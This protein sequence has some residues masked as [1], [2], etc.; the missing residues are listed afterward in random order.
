MRACRFTLALILALLL[1]PAIARGAVL[2]GSPGVAPWSDK[3]AGGT[4]EA[5]QY[6]ATSSGIVQSVSL[7]GDSGETTSPILVGI[8]S[9]VNNHPGVPLATTVIP[10]PRES[11]WNTVSISPVLVTAGSTYW[12]A[13]LAT[14]G[15]LAVRD[16][17]KGQGPTEESQSHGLL[18]LPASW[19]T[20]RVWANSPASFYASGTDVLEEVVEPEEESREA[21][22]EAAAETAEREAREKSEREGQAG[23]ESREE[24]LAR[25]REE[26]VA[27]RQERKAAREARKH[28]QQVA[29]ETREA[30]EKAARENEEKVTREGHEAEERAARE[31]E[32]QATREREAQEHEQQQ[33]GTCTTTVGPATAASTIA[34]DIRGAA[35]GSTVCL[36]AGN[37]PQLS[38]NG[39]VSRSSFATVRAVA[40]QTVNVAGLVLRGA[41]HLAFEH[42]HFS[43]EANVENSTGSTDAYLRFAYDAWEH[44]NSGI[45]METDSGPA[46]SHVAIEHD[47]FVSILTEGGKGCA[48]GRDGG[49]AVTNHGANGVT[50]A[51]NLF[52][53][54]SYHYI[55]GGAE[56]REGMAVEHNTFL[57]PEPQVS[58]EHHDNV[59][60]IWQGG[61]NNSFSHNLVWG[62]SQSSPQTDP[63]TLIFE[64]GAGGRECAVRMEDF[65][66]EDNLF[67]HATSSAN[68]E[69]V[70]EIEGYAVRHNTAYGFGAGWQGYDTACP[71]GSNHTITNNI[72][73]SGSTPGWA[74]FTC[75]SGSCVFDENVS[76]DGRTACEFRALSCNAAWAPAWKSISWKPTVGEA[77]PPAGYYKPEGLTVAAGYEGQVG[78]CG[79]TGP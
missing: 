65:S 6:T 52:K 56:N 26:R 69:Q 10:V 54:V 58:C 23:H 50:V 43:E 12:L 24:E 31:R 60:Q 71:G 28:E 46:I 30:E 59:W 53:E 61:V 4:A 49:Q 48:S 3:T 15:T 74:G 66:V 5:W 42:L 32:E 73:S 78:A 34:S 51:Y 44:V 47:R 17:E 62:E 36:Q 75:T 68:I 33:D 55:Q 76:S 41:Q 18:A 70:G 67:I 8:Y 29:R 37:Y 39:S 63:I 2:V 1:A 21:E 79:L 7:Y 9:D 11:S 25:K 77:C 40:G 35:S 72:M 14:A 57:G 27:R 16:S 38:V 64:N 22:E 20:G 45:F 13:A 19:V